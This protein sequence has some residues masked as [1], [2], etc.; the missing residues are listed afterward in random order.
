MTHGLT[1]E[2]WRLHN[3][4]IFLWNITNWVQ[5]YSKVITTRVQ[6]TWI[7]WAGT[8]DVPNGP[9]YGCAYICAHNML[10]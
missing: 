5:K 4:Y 8:N 9:K 2:N 7:T 6:E 10:F 1:E 3:I